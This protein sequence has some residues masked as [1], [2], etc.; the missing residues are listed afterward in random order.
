[1]FISTHADDI[2]GGEAEAALVEAL[3]LHDVADLLVGLAFVA[4]A[5]DFVAGHGAPVAGT[6]TLSR[7]VSYNSEDEVGLQDYVFY[8]NTHLHTQL[9]ARNG[10]R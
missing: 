6:Q 9:L 7:E 3:P 1:M 8:T 4:I 5:D 10:F 2:R